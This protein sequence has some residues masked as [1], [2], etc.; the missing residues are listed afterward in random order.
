[1]SLVTLAVTC[2]SISQLAVCKVSALDMKF[3]DLI[4]VSHSGVAED[5]GCD[6]ML[7]CVAWLV[8]AQQ[9]F[10]LSRTTCPEAQQL[11]PQDLNLR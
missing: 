5:V 7:C 1:M 10:K 3:F 9:P 11:I 4:C 8:E 6:M 2:L